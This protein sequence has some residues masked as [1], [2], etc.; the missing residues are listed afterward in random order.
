MKEFPSFRL[1]YALDY[2]GGSKFGC[3]RIPFP[4]GAFFLFRE[5]FV[6]RDDPDFNPRRAK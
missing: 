3:F 1:S 4:R 6:N 2:R 5:G